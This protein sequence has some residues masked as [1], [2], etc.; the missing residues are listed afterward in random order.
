VLIA[1]RARL[2]G[3]DDRYENPNAAPGGAEITPTPKL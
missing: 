1:D 3:A 2:H